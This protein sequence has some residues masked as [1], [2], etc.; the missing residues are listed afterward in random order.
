VPSLTVPL[1]FM[2]T[3]HQDQ[4]AWIESGD[5]L[6]DL[7][8]EISGRD[9][10]GRSSV[11]DVG[12]GTKLA[13]VFAD[14]RRPVGRYVGVDV[15]AEMIEWLRGEVTDPRFSFHHLPAHNE[16]YN[17]DG[18]PLDSIEALPVGDEQFDV[19][20]LFSVFTHLGPHDYRP[21]LRLLRPH[22]APGGRLVYSLYVRGSGGTAGDP[23]VAFRDLDDE[24]ATEQFTDA[25]V[26][27][28]AAGD[29]EVAASLAGPGAAASAGE[30]WAPLSAWL[31]R[32]P[33]DIRA[34]AAELRAQ[35]A[36]PDLAL[37]TRWARQIVDGVDAA[38]AFE[39]RNPDNPLEL[40]VYTRELALDLVEGTGWE[41]VALHP[42]D[43]PHIQDHLVCRPA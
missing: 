34:E 5:R 9:D 25:L 33:A 1:R 3:A 31:D 35:G 12:C 18:E 4:Q 27:R 32:A 36:Q 39:D 26:R 17:P 29:P 20:C 21:L 41:V 11:L 38:P 2:A 19:I 42:P 23:E 13:K 15:N 43:L 14:G 40:A 6:V 7:L 24:A 10:L 37:V 8:C 28:L 30:R 16:M 22:I